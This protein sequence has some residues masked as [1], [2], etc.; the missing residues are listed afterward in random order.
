MADSQGVDFLFE[1]SVGG[2]IPIVFPLKQSLSGNK[3]REVIGIV[4]GTT[5]YILSK[6]SQQKSPFEEVLKEAQDLGY[7][8][9]DPSSDVEGY[10]SARKISIL[11]SIAFNS[12]VTFPDVYVEGITRITPLDIKYGHELGYVIKLL[13]IAKEEQEG[14][15]QVR[16]HPAFI[17]RTHPLAAVSGV[18]NAVF[19]R[20]DAVGD[21]M[22]YGR[23]AGQTPTA[24][25][26]VGDIMDIVRNIERENTG[27]ISC[28]CYEN[29]EIV[30]IS[31]IKAKYYIRLMVKDRPGV[32][33]S[34][35]GVFGN[36]NVSLATVLQKTTGQEDAQLV[37][38][39]HLVEEADL[40]DALT[41][42]SGMNI[43][44]AIENVIR[45]EGVEDNES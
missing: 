31:S 34:I 17:P 40:R 36:Q 8:E 32:L 24:S 18:Y 33:A 14:K 13:A 26:V 27:R 44:G 43:V 4:N 42:F 21:L 23:G 38:I 19:V 12:R 30:S 25:A 1:A 15:I 39:T 28:T 35:A 11:A 9:A 10:D 22:F 7:A 45:L 20:G 16:V 3:I 29:K 6:M 41:I 2:G 37:L 5:N